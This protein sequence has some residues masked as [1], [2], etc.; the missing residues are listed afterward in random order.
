MSDTIKL[1]HLLSLAVRR[2]AWARR[3]Y[4][5]GLTYPDGSG[6][7]ALALKYAEQWAASAIEARNAAVGFASR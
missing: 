3:D 1:N 7:R 2:D 5:R 6:A 4:A